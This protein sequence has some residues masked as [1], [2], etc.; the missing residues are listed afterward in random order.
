MFGVLRVLGQPWTWVR[1]IRLLKDIVVTQFN[2]ILYLQREIQAEVRELHQSSLLAAIHVIE[3]QK[4]AREQL[5]QENARLEQRIAAL[6]KQLGVAS[7]P[8]S[9]PPASERNRAA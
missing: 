2:Q 5:V 9:A 1:R 8:V 4:R 7:E 3:E 6:E